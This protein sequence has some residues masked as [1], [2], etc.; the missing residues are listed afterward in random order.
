MARDWVWRWCNKSY[1]TTA[2]R[3]TCAAVP[4]RGRGLTFGCR[5]SRGKE[6]LRDMSY[7]ARRKPDVFGFHVALTP[8][9][10]PLARVSVLLLSGVRLRFLRFDRA[11]DH[12]TA[13]DGVDFLLQRRHVARGQA[14]GERRA[15][16]ALAGNVIE[17]G[18]SVLA[19]FPV[20]QE[21]VK[22]ARGILNTAGGGNTYGPPPLNPREMS[23]GLR[24][25]YVP[26]CRLSR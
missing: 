5:G 10:S 18:H 2:A 20:H 15:A 22:F 24:K 6:R 16:F 21:L 8:R 13:R 3:S 12:E 26:W 23:R 1:R 19:D 4:A 11:S 9:R 7:Q 14:G 17:H 25:F